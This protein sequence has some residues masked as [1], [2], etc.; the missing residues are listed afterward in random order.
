MP[1][2]SAVYSASCIARL[3]AGDASVAAAVLEVV[4][5]RQ[6]DVCVAQFN[7]RQRAPAEVITG[8]TSSMNTSHSSYCQNAYTAE[9]A[10]LKSYLRPQKRHVSCRH[11]RQ[12]AEAADG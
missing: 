5:K 12:T 9:V 4:P 8:L 11:R 6:Q 10:V 2:S 7:T 3:A 1:D